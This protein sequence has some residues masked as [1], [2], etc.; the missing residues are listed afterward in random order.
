MKKY[1][2]ALSAVAVLCLGANAK[3]HEVKMLDVN[4]EG[5]MVF[6]PGFLQIEPGDSVTFVPTHKT[7]WAKSVVIPEGAS[8]FES[9]LDEKATFSFDKEGVYIYECPPHKIMNMMGIIQVGKATNL[10]KV[11]LAIPKL[12]KRA[13]ENKGRLEK[14]AKQIKE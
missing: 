12:E 11:R 4:S 7:H 6:E 8:K 5:T 10:E 9:K 1:L 3:N 13:S 14:Y 2:L